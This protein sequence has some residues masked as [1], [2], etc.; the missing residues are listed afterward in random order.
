MSNI[1]VTIIVSMRY[2]NME[3]SVTMT[4]ILTNRIESIPVRITVGLSILPSHSM[5][6]I[7]GTM[8]SK[9]IFL[10]LSFIRY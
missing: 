2:I 10:E 9:Q 8:K 4:Q 5:Q 6:G 1:T 3:T 7:M